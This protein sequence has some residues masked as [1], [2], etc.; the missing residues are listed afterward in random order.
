[1]VDLF[2]DMR[3]MGICSLSRHLLE[4]VGANWNK[5]KFPPPQPGNRRKIMKGKLE[6]LEELRVNLSRSCATSRYLNL[7]LLE[8]FIQMALSELNT[9]IPQ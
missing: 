3:L 7:Q 4:R 5:P 1:M 9:I 2:Q 8:Y 6:L